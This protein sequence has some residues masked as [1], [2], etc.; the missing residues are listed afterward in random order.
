MDQDIRLNVLDVKLNVSIH[1]IGLSLLKRDV[2]YTL[3]HNTLLT[4]TLDFIYHDSMLTLLQ[5]VV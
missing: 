5:K 3:A 4:N 1:P 2:V